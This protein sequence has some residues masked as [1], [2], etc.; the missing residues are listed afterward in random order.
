MDTLRT[1]LPHE[2]FGDPLC[3]GCLFGVIH[4]EQAALVCDA[5][6]L[7]VRRVPV[8]DLQRTIH[9]MERMLALAIDLDEDRNT[10]RFLE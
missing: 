4:E 1:S 6:Q 7:V 10:D 3:S 5:C 9:E 8:H 2:F